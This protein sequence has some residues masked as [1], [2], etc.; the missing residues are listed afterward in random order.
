[1]TTFEVVPADGLDHRVERCWTELCAASPSFFLS[2]DAIRTWLLHQDGAS[3]LRVLIAR[4]DSRPVLACTLGT[5]S[6]VRHGVFRGVALSLNSTGEQSSDF[7]YLEHNDILVAPDESSSELIGETLQYLSDRWP[8]PWD[9]LRLPGVSDRSSAFRALVDG[10]P[11]PLVV[12]IDNDTVSP[13][14]DF[15]RIR[16]S[17]LDYT[18]TLSVNTRRQL[19]RTMR[20]YEREGALSLEV[21]TGVDDSLRI[22]DDLIEL[23]NRSWRARSRIGA[24]A[25]ERV[26]RFHRDLVACCSPK[27]TVQLLR[28]CCGNRTIG[29][30]YMFLASDTVS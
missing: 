28:L 1:M 7:L 5:R 14:I 19:N 27:T 9:E 18:T 22:L 17:G 21:A 4:H 25:D 30:L 15:E 10:P 24:F 20:A 16:D 2:W 3:N 13:F 8:E 26:V 12:E 11:R 29:C 23:H 6:F